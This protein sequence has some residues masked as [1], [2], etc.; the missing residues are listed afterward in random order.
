MQKRKKS[1]TKP[2]LFELSDFQK[3]Q[4]VIV[5]FSVILSV[6]RVVL[7]KKDNCNVNFNYS[8]ESIYKN[9]TIMPGT[10][11]WLSEGDVKR[12]TL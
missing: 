6:S 12:H 8:D 2:Y 1:N 10:Q 11:C 9:L 4:K 7:T 5:V 3:R